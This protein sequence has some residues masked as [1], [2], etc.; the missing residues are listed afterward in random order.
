MAFNPAAAA[1]A[2]NA[3]SHLQLFAASQPST[4]IKT[5]QP[6]SALVTN[7]P[8]VTSM[9][10]NMEE[11]NVATDTTRFL[12]A[13]GPL[14]TPGGLTTFPHPME[15]EAAAFRAAVAQ[16]AIPFPIYPGLHPAVRPFFINYMSIRCFS[17]WLKNYRVNVFDGLGRIKIDGP[18]RR[19]LEMKPEMMGAVRVGP[20]FFFDPMPY[21]PYASGLDGVRRKNATRETTAPL[22][23][24]LNEHRKNPYPTKA[25]KIMLALLTKM[26]LTQV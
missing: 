4:P 2:F 18:G 17:N 6:A 12:N 14:L 19:I 24:W 8:A 5:E 11:V 15:Q 22:K 20:G 9:G 21:H 25:E 10:S 23:S 13:S 3:Q 16:G 1:A 26:T 7:V